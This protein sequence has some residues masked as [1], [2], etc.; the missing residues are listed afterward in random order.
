MEKV[1]SKRRG[2]RRK[3]RNCEKGRVEENREDAHPWIANANLV[4]QSEIP[5]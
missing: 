3:M 5:S 4:T 1:E 2:E